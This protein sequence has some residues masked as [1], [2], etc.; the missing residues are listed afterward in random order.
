MLCTLQLATALAVRGQDTIAF[1]AG[2][3]LIASIDE[4]GEEYILCNIDENGKQ[5]SKTISI[6]NIRRINYKSGYI[7]RFDLSDTQNKDKIEF[8]T[9]TTALYK[10]IELDD[11]NV[12]VDNGRKDSLIALKDIASIIY[13]N[14]FKEQYNAL[15]LQA[16][17][18]PVKENYTVKSSSEDKKSVFNFPAEKNAGA[19]TASAPLLKL[20]NTISK[21]EEIASETI[22]D[23]IS[24]GIGF[25]IDSISNMSSQ[26]NLYDLLVRNVLVK[27]GKK[28]YPVLTLRR[29]ICDY[30]ITGSISSPQ[31]QFVLWENGKLKSRFTIST[32]FNF[33]YDDMLKSIYMKLDSA[34][35]GR[36]LPAKSVKL[37]LP[38]IPVTDFASTQG[39]RYNLLL[40]AVNYTP[41]LDDY[42][43]IS[44]E[45]LKPTADIDTTTLSKLLS[46]SF[47]RLSIRE[48]RKNSA[49]LRYSSVLENYN[50]ILPQFPLAAINKRKERIPFYQFETGLKVKNVN[51]E[52]LRYLE[53]LYPIYTSKTLKGFFF[54]SS[55]VDEKAKNAAREAIL[56]LYKRPGVPL[57]YLQAGK[58]FMK[59]DLYDAAI[60]S[61]TA[62]LFV[63]NS[64]NAAASFKEF[65]KAALF[66]QLSAA[67][68]A[69]DQVA[70][71]IICSH[72]AGFHEKLYSGKYYVS[73]NQSMAE[74]T[75]KLT[76]YFDKV[77]TDAI[78]ARKKKRAASLLGVLT[79]VT[80]VVSAVNDGY[81]GNS[82]LSAQTQ[83]YVNSAVDN[84]GKGAE[85]KD[86]SRS[87][88]EKAAEVFKKSF[89]EM[90]DQLHNDNNTINTSKPI[91]AVDFIEI[92]SD[93]G[94][95]EQ[96]TSEMP[97]FLTAVPTLRPLVTRYFSQISAGNKEPALL[98]EIYLTLGK[99]EL[100]LF[101]I[102]AT[103][104]KS[105][106]KTLLD[107]K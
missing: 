84:I 24:L 86:A 52:P 99:L 82:A 60:E 76:E 79:T 105:S 12:L 53:C 49:Y 6:T 85:I 56:P 50:R 71:A 7:E 90:M 93:N 96:I 3:I 63:I 1:K 51:P 92:L 62:G 77:E 89:G 17:P 61:Y 67:Y 43:A 101:S 55:F 83:S 2:Q 33:V 14:G 39:V 72:L 41:P 31:S 26:F 35:T 44:K 64:I 78:E 37:S 73:D 15:V 16:T 20:R 5:K 100:A 42:I 27:K 80:A 8:I 34:I 36:T 68:Y 19:S 22:N 48:K 30:Y 104:K 97:G 10:I 29:G 54:E 25:I 94:A 69:N 59:Y 107:Y 46:Y 87:A 18:V 103:G 70:S 57:T 9:G 13:S 40:N 106:E 66:T 75:S 4:V 38:E 98:K 88:T 102:E 81:S 58:E 32:A 65:L 28:V 95:I 45:Y 74:A 21:K 11:I 47:T 91:F 23:P